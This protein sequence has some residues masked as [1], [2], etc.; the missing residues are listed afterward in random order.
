MVL[1]L[2]QL[3]HCSAKT[4]IWSI[5]NHKSICSDSKHDGTEEK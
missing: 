1:V 5:D 4:G 3:D 2:L